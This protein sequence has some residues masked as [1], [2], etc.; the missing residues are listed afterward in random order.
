MSAVSPEIISV[1]LGNKWQGALYPLMILPLCM[2]IRM[3]TPPISQ[4]TNALGVPEAAIKAQVVSLF[5]TCLGT[6]AGISI[7]GIRGLSIAWCIIAPL[8]VWVLLFFTRPVLNITLFNIVSVL[9]KPGLAAA[10]MYTAIFVLRERNVSEALC[11]LM[12]ISISF[13]SHFA[14]G[15]FCLSGASIYALTIWMSDRRGVNELF[16]LIRA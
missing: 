4:S 16:S 2:P 11:N 13:S 5:I 9:I 15:L 6:L 14:L 12:G 10:I 7:D 8:N 1:V 3:L